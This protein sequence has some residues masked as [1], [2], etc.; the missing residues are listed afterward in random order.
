MERVASPFDV[1]N[2]PDSLDAKGLWNVCISYGLLVDAFIANKR[3]IGVRTTTLKDQDLI[4]IEDSSTVLLLKV[5]DVDSMGNMYTISKSP[6][7][8][9]KVDECMIWVEISAEDSIAMG[10]GR[11]C[12]ATKSH[13][14]ISE[15]IHVEVHVQEI[16]TWSVNISDNSLDTSS[17]IDVNE[18]INAAD[19]AN[20]VEDNSI[21]DL[22][23]LNENLN[24]MDHDFKD[25]KEP[26]KNPE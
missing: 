5:K 6:Y 14:N 8:S 11:V 12:I 17:N 13:K 9:F 19:A 3:S 4:T 10:T 20:S 24:N 18:V 7:P 16:Y 23:D 26:M 25:D 15:K 2:L 21:D 22:K 1:S